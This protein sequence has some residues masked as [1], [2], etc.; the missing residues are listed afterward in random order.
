MLGDGK[1]EQRRRK[2]TDLSLADAPAT[3]PPLVITVK[4]AHD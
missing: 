3:S 1:L 4:Q 2:Q